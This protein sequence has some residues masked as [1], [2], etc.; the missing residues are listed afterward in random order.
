MLTAGA[1]DPFVQRALLICLLGGITVFVS[2]QIIF[3]LL[4]CFWSKVITSSPQRLSLQKILHLEMTGFGTVSYH[5]M[6]GK[7][8]PFSGL[9]IPGGLKQLTVETDSEP[10]MTYACKKGFV[11]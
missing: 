4:L 7:S 1:S 3:F 6:T 9:P 8:F 11:D 5:F 2:V 10:Q